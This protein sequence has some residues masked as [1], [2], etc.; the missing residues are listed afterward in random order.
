MVKQNPSEPI[1]L[2]A[3]RSDTPSAGGAGPGWTYRPTPTSNGP[4]GL[5][6]RPEKP[7]AAPPPLETPSE[8]GPQQPPG[9]KPRGRRLLRPIAAA[10]G[11]LFF[12]SAGAAGYVYWNDASHF[13][14]TDDAFIAA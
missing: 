1:V 7:A 12:A 5:L 4:V 11:L 6:E 3:R 10:L 2:E 8:H 13:E 9:D 14:S